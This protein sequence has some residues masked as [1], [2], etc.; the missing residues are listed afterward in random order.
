MKSDLNLKKIAVFNYSAEAFTCKGRL[1]VEG[2]PVFMRDNFTVDADPL[3]SQAIGGVK[4]Y[5]K[6]TDY[7]RGLQVLEEINKYS[8]TNEGEPIICP[9]CRSNKVQMLSVIN[10]VKSIFSF[11]IGLFLIV[12]PF[13]VKYIYVCDNCEFKFKKI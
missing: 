13:Y 7:E 10:D 4:L 12:L 3:F 2:I 1:E 6:E 11:I 9:R 8:L 5:V